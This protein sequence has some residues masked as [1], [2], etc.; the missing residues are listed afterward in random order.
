[1]NNAGMEILKIVSEVCAIDPEKIRKDADI[2]QEYGV[3]SMMAIKILAALDIQYNIEISTEEAMK[4][5]TLN[6]LE[7]LVEKLV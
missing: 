7:K 2:Y 4:I 5:R 6:E 1:M 3:D